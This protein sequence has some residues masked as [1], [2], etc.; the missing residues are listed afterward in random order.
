MR[1]Y[2]CLQQLVGWVDRHMFGV[3]SLSSNTAIWSELRTNGPNFSGMNMGLCVPFALGLSLA[4][5]RRTVIALD[6]D[7]SLMNNTSSLLSVGD[8]RPSNLVIVVMDNQSYAR[9]GPTASSRNADLE[10]IARGA[11]IE[12]TATIRTEAEFEQHVKPALRQPGPSFFRVIVEAETE[13]LIGNR[14]RVYGQAMKTRFMELVSEHPDY[15]KW[16]ETAA[17]SAARQAVS[18]S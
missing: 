10:A 13:R 17:H 15:Q 9:M 1:R 12:H 11:G 14:R 7:G 2:D 8:V 4:F 6:S 5:P 16:N 3:T 18:D